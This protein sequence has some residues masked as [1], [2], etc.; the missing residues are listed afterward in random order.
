MGSCRTVWG[1]H[2]KTSAGPSGLLTGTM[3]SPVSVRACVC[4]CVG[5]GQQATEFRKS[6]KTFYCTPPAKCS[7]AAIHYSQTLIDYLYL[8]QKDAAGF[9]MPTSRA[10]MLTSNLYSP[11]RPS[12]CL[13]LEVTILAVCATPMG[14]DRIR[15]TEWLS[16]YTWV[17]VR[18]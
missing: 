11:V 9:I 4:V 17:G 3:C 14:A 7:Q 1:G 6:G 16:T 8:S 13:G 10:F 2:H 18:V 15:R 12:C 5:G